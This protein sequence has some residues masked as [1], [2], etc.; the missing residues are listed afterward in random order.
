M[1]PNP[2]IH[3]HCFSFS[4]LFFFFFFAGNW[5]TKDLDGVIPVSHLTCIELRPLHNQLNSLHSSM[6]NIEVLKVASISCR[7]PMQKLQKLFFKGVLFSS[8]EEIQTHDVNIELKLQ[9]QRFLIFFS[10]YW[11]NK[12]SSEENK[13]PRKLFEAS[14]VA[15]SAIWILAIVRAGHDAPARRRQSDHCWQS[16]TRRSYS[17]HGGGPFK[18]GSLS[19]S[20]PW[21]L[22]IPTHAAA[23]SPQPP[24]HLVKSPIR[25]QGWKIQTAFIVLLRALSRKPSR[26]GGVYCM[27][28]PVLT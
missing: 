14:K 21:R 27:A 23:S 15:G 20:H 1:H 4:L 16:V 6:F 13:V 17:Y 19:D 12:L 18:Y 26:G 22:K 11:I 10:H 7:C 3:S 28:L 8:V 9:I 25:A 2:S 24:P 5:R